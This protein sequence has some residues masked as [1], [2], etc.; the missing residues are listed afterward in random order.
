MQARQLRFQMQCLAIVLGM[1]AAWPTV[2]AADAEGFVVLPDNTPRFSGPGGRESNVFE[3]LATREQTGGVFGL[4][5]LTVAPQGGPGVHIH[6]GE[7]EFFY[8]LQGEF[9]FKVGDRV[10]SSPVGTFVFVPRGQG[11]TFQNL[12]TEPGVLLGGVLPGGLEGLFTETSGAD[13][14]QLKKLAEKYRI[15][16]IGPPLGR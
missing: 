10:V 3:I 2:V 7:D 1:V 4:F 9:H 14:E 6:R 11:H 12:S 5:R 15:E 13:A 16:F 8:V